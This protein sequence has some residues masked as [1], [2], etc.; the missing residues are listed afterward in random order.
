VMRMYHI[1]DREDYHKY[2]YSSLTS[3]EL[4]IGTTSYAG[5]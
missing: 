3:L 5:Q 1:Q 2:V 4:M